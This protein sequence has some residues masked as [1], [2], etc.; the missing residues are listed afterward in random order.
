MNVP[1][2]EPYLIV[3]G[4]DADAPGSYADFL[5]VQPLFEE[6]RAQIKAAQDAGKGGESYIQIV[7]EL[8]KPRL[9]MSDGSDP[10]LHIKRVS[11]TQVAVLIAEF[12]GTADKVDDEAVPK[13]N[14]APSTGTPLVLATNGHRSGS[15]VGRLAK[16][17]TSRPG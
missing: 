7:F 11:L 15:K 8:I 3:K 13:A 16:S 1:A 10:E 6:I 2:T 12:L 4:F 5:V 9:R 17:G 14:G